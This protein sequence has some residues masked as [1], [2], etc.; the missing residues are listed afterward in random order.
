M[1]QL[2]DSQRPC[3]STAWL[4]R[5]Y[6]NEEQ[7]W[8]GLVFEVTQRLE[9]KLGL[10]HR[11]LMG[12]WWVGRPWRFLWLVCTDMRFCAATAYNWRT[13]RCDMVLRCFL[14]LLLVLALVG[15]S[16]GV[17]IWEL[18]QQEAAARNA[19]I[20]IRPTNTTNG[21]AVANTPVSGL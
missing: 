16:M 14:P 15:V 13:R 11:C 3:C 21:T 20:S 1:C 12:Q 10:K 19:T 7:V 17:G 2:H 6:L 4:C 8:S 18:Q 9:E 5:Q